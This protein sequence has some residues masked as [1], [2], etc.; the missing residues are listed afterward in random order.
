MWV[1]MYYT[2]S[3]SLL[4]G[5]TCNIHSHPVVYLSV[6]NMWTHMQHSYLCYILWDS[7]DSCRSPFLVVHIGMCI[8]HR[9]TSRP[10][11]TSLRQLDLKVSCGSYKMQTYLGVLNVGP[12]VPKVVIYGYVSVSYGSTCTTCDRVMMTR[13]VT[14]GSKCPKCGR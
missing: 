11:C 8:Y 1:L 2:H 9:R 12:H 7:H 5:P 13:G 4:Y 3:E 14:C 6:W 10:T